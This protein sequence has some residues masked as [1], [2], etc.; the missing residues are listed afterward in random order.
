MSMNDE[1]EEIEQRLHKLESAIGN[2]RK[3]SHPALEGFELLNDDLFLSSFSVEDCRKFHSAHDTAEYVLEEL[4]ALDDSNI[5]INIAAFCFLLS[6]SHSAVEEA[7]FSKC[8]DF[9]M[10]LIR[11]S[12]SPE[13]IFGSGEALDLHENMARE[14]LIQAVASRRPSVKFR[15]IQNALTLISK[16][17]DAANAD[18][19][20]LSLS[21]IIPTVPLLRETT[22]LLRT[23]LDIRQDSEL[24][25]GPV[26][27][28]LTSIQTVLD[29]L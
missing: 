28:A 4:I 13:P 24:L 10:D 20:L 16:R 2:S 23:Y 14:L 7:A 29:T 21:R 15:K 12:T 9:F 27:Y 11:R 17:S 1:L 8:F 5:E 26:G 19:L 3:G 6:E 18:D 25:I 22:I